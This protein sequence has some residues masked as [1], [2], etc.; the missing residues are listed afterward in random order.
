M[1]ASAACAIDAEA[2]GSE[3]Y[4]VNRLTT[5]EHSASLIRGIPPHESKR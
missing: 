1:A 2:D 4:N 5:M 3:V